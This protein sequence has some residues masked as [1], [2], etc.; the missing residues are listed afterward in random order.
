MGP[1]L[2]GTEANLHQLQALFHFPEA[3]ANGFPSPGEWE[4]SPCFIEGA[5]EL[6]GLPD[7]TPS[8]AISS[9]YRTMASRSGSASPTR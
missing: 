1:P 6:V 4:L 5:D 9:K 2:H 8:L 7:R 3:P